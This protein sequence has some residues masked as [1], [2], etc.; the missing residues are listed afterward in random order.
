MPVQRWYGTTLPANRY[1]LMSL[2]LP[3]M[4]SLR[5]FRDTNFVKVSSVALESAIESIVLQ[6]GHSTDDLQL[7]NQVYYTH[8]PVQSTVMPQWWASLLISG[9]SDFHFD[10]FFHNRGDDA[11]AVTVRKKLSVLSGKTAERL[12]YIV[13]TV[14]CHLP[15]RPLLFSGGCCSLLFLVWLF[16]PLH[17]LTCF[18]YTQFLFFPTWV[19]YC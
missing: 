4:S 5:S 15:E 9:L 1:R 16:I 7:E 8:C 11:G 10:T 12:L 6:Y 13:F 18:S 19:L 14:M 17:T 3:L 2:S